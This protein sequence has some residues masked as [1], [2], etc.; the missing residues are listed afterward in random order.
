MAQFNLGNV[1]AQA[2][3]IKA[4][5][6]ANDPGSVQNQL[7]QTQL[8][9]AKGQLDEQT[10]MRNTRALYQSFLEMSANPQGIPAKVRQMQAQGLIGPEWQPN[11]PLEELAADAGKQAQILGQI[12][13]VKGPEGFTLSPGQTRFGPNGQPVATVPAAEPKSDV[14]SPEAY[15]QR[16]ALNR[17]R[18]EAD[19]QAAIEKE[20]AKATQEIASDQPRRQQ[21][22][23]NKRA[24]VSL[25]QEDISRAMQNSNGWTT[26]F[27]G[28]A[29]SLI[30]G[31]PAH[32]LAATLD[33]IKANIGF[34]KLAQMKAESKTGGA[35][36]QV[37]ERELALLQSVWGALAQSQSEKQFEYNLA[38]LSRQM[39]KSW[40]AVEEAYQKDYGTPYTDEA[41]GGDAEIEALLRKYANP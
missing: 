34:D 35:L 7:A 30:P 5:R 29:L 6:N 3:Q 12:L 28:S 15:Q 39:E 21:Q 17:A 4:L 14:L 19:A 27:F 32:D 37:T 2:E 41:F 9:S 24:Q 26:G 16:L 38:R 33:S 36:G 22:M 11:K 31:T 40:K 1:L 25:V 13:G 23:E 8:Q 18:T 10:R 20:K